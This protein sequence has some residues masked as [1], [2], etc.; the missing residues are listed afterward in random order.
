MIEQAILNLLA[1]LIR[2]CV[3]KLKVI[4]RRVLRSLIPI[5][6]VI[7]RVKVIAVRVR[8]DV[9]IIAICVATYIQLVTV[10]KGEVGG[11]QVNKPRG[12]CAMPPVVVIGVV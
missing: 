8:D 9:I 12:I 6:L 3:I 2:R 1:H 7:V 4:L 10:I 5:L 11:R